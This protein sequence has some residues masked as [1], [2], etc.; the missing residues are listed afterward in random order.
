[1]SD[2]ASVRYLNHHQ[3]LAKSE[4]SSDARTMI[5]RLRSRKAYKDLAQGFN[6]GLPQLTR[7]ALTGR[8]VR[9]PR[10]W[11]LL[12]APSFERCSL[13]PYRANRVKNTQPRVETLG[14]VLFPFRGRQGTQPNAKRQTP[15]A[16]RQT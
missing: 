7:H 4:A 2:E 9:F 11:A 12:P 5:N 6:P 10:D 16:K 8:Q 1:M 15:S 3:Q 13:G 14:S